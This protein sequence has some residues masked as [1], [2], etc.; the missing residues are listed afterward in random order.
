MLRGHFVF[1]KSFNIKTFQFKVYDPDTY[2]IPQFKDNHQETLYL[3]DR[4]QSDNA[5][6]NNPF[7]KYK[8]KS[9]RIVECSFKK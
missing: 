1:A 3:Y 7:T 4:D 9:V 2:Q 5:N 6:V 8:I